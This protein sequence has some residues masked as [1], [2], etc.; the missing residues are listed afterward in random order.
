M[1]RKSDPITVEELREIKEQLHTCEIGDALREKLAKRIDAEIK[2]REKAGE[3]GGRPKNSEIRS[4]MQEIDREGFEGA[5][6]K[7]SQKHWERDEYSQD[8]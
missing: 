1:P 7:V 5:L 3:K 4:Q 6:K 2:R 8:G